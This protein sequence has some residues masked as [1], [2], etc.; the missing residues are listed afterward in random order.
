MIKRLLLA[1]LLLA[2]QAAYAI[3]PAKLVRLDARNPLSS[4][5][6]G[7]AYIRST[8]PTMFLDPD[9]VGSDRENLALQ[10]ED[11]SNAAWNK[12]RS[13]ISSN[14]VANPV[15]GATTAD[16]LIE[17]ATAA[18]SHRT[19]VAGA[20]N[21]VSGQVY[22]ISVYAKIKE[23]HISI[24]FDGAAF[25]GNP[26]A[27]FD[28]TTC[29]VNSVG[30]GVTA[31]AE[32]LANGWCRLIGTMTATSTGAA[33]PGF[34]LASTPATVGYNGDATSGA[35]IFGAQ[36][37]RASQ[38][39]TYTATTATPI[40]GP[41]PSISS[42]GLTASIGSLYGS[43]AA[44]TQSTD[45]NKPILSR[46]DR[47]ENLLTYSDT[48][49]N[50]AWDKA[51]YPTTFSA[52]TLTA[53]AGAARHG[54]FNNSYTTATA[55]ATYRITFDVEKGTH[56]YISIADF[57][58]F[59]WHTAV[60]DINTGTLG[61][62]LNATSSKV[63]NGT[64]R[65]FFSMDFTRTN[66]GTI[67]PL[68]CFVAASTTTQC[69]SFTAAGT[70]TVK[71][72]SAQLQRS[73]MQPT[74]I[75][76]T[77]APVYGSLTGRRMLTFDGTNDQLSTT[78]TWGD[79]F[80]ASAKT[81]FIVGQS[82]AF[83]ADQNYLSDN[84]ASY[85]RICYHNSSGYI[86]LRNNDGSPDQTPTSPPSAG[87]PFVLGIYHDGTN[88]GSAL[89]RGTY[90]TAASGATAVTA[91]VVHMGSIGGSAYLNGQLGPIITFNRVL[92][93]PERDMIRQILQKFWRVG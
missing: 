23:R 69:A 24:R 49:S 91:G 76:T 87:V 53:T 20:I 30:S 57:G 74:Y 79:L 81:A 41:S 26:Y 10:S 60:L 52:P 3:T 59:A 4:I 43:T 55:G 61:T 93:Q 31:T 86:G 80:G 54:T 14:S 15:D 5:E 66:G 62:T 40:Y 47:V 82:A 6:A 2:T 16:T 70:E 9:Y 51:T 77:T 37:K 28:L 46:P 29:A 44:F 48:F 35:Y 75:A 36:L 21:V 13:S 25:S 71:I 50:A 33:Y 27:H 92:T 17:D 34:Y 18:N 63:A 22:N 58:D 1:G 73:S 42:V 78:S 72:Y 85:G 19:D 32:S 89:N 88:I 39:S 68:V 67:A 83:A 84:T 90:A 12:T 7:R 45:A 65:Y 11:F 56:Q 38:S 8:K 64:D